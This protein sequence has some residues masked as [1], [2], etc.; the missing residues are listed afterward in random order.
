MK[1]ALILA[2]AKT[3]FPA[4][5]QTPAIPKEAGLWAPLLIK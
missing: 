2:A 4:D 5:G 1:L 3:T